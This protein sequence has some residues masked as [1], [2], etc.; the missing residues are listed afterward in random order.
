VAGW[1][2][3]VGLAIAVALALHHL[4]E[5]P[6][7]RWLR[8][9]LGRRAPSTAPVYPPDHDRVLASIGR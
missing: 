5:V 4:V 2:A 1:S 3:Y 7:E 9:R 6:A 8:H